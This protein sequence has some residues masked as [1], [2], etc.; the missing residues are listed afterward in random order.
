MLK[1]SKS[2]KQKLA[3]CHPKLQIL[4]NDIIK[5]RDCTV[6]DG[7]RTRVRQDRYFAEKKSKV[8]Y[9]NSKHNSMPSN[10][11]DVAPYV[12]RR[13]S[14]D[15]HQCYHFAGYVL[16]WAELL[17]INIIWGGDWDADHDINNQSFNDLTHFQLVEE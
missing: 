1:F 8:K 15:V 14:W 3:T 16:A 17:G 5:H 13:I 6:V 11:V 12:K 4:F 7:H 2:S 10:A 9:P